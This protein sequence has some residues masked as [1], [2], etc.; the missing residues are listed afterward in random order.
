MPPTNGCTLSA[1]TH[2]IEEIVME[3]HVYKTIE[4]TGTSSAGPD[5]AVE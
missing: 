3:N 1:L 4:I 2:V 5:D